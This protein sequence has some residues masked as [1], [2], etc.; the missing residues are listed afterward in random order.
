MERAAERKAA[1][2]AGATETLP[3]GKVVPPPS[4]RYTPKAKPK[5]K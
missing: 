1:K 5:K 3:S 2:K 4:K